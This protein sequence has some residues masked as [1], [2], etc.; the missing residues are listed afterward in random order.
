MPSLFCPLTR[1]SKFRKLNLIFFPLPQRGRGV[2][3]C[4]TCSVYVKMADAII[5]LPLLL[6]KCSVASCTIC[7][8]VNWLYRRCA[9]AICPPNEFDSVQFLTFC[10]FAFLTTFDFTAAAVAS[11]SSAKICERIQAAYSVIA[12]RKCSLRNC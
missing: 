1:K 2:V 11:E 5:H 9:S 8:H 10:Q 3:D 6:L 12:P 7:F 4:F